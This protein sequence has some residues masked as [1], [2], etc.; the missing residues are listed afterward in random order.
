MHRMDARVSLLAVVIVSLPTL[1]SAQIF[2]PYPGP[3]PWFSPA[4]VPVPVVDVAPATPA[5]QKVLDVLAGVERGLR[6]TSYQ[7]VTRV[8]EGAG[9][10]HWDCSGMA[11]WVLRRGAPTARRAIAAQRPLARDFYNAI[12]RSP[13]GQQRR[14]WQ[15]LTSPAE[16]R[17]GDVYAWMKAPM[18]RHRRNTGHVGFVIGPAAPSPQFPNVWLMRVADATAIAHGHDDSRPLGSGGGYGTATM[19]FLFD[20]ATNEPIAYGWY[21]HG[22][23]PENFI[24]TKIVFG[25]VW[26]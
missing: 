2:S 23:D 14:G 5:A 1:A 17:P 11:E 25:R 4:P 26:R 21:G 12:A 8:D 18:F 9:L 7:H 6:S 10:Y 24:P 3:A 16:I 19:G 22:Q 20:P 15:R 13:A